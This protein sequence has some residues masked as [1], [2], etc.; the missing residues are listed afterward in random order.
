MTRLWR[1]VVRLERLPLPPLEV[2]APA[3]PAVPPS[4]P[5]LALQLD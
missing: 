1:S 3:E 2:E 5:D 4:V